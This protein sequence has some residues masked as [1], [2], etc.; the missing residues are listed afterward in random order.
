MNYKRKKSLHKTLDYG[1]ANKKFE[2]KKKHK[3][4]PKIDILV[5]LTENIVILDGWF[6]LKIVKGKLNSNWIRDFQ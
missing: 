1:F 6:G 2:T 3:C 5:Q 4:N